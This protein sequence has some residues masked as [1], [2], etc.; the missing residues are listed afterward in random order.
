MSTI[1]NEIINA[2]EGKWP[3]FIFKNEE[4]EPVNF[5]YNQNNIFYINGE[6]DTIFNEKLRYM[7]INPYTLECTF[8]TFKI[9]DKDISLYLVILNNIAI[10]IST[11]NDP[12]F[13]TFERTSPPIPTTSPPPTPPPTPSPT[14]IPIVDPSYMLGEWI[15]YSL[16]IGQAG[17]VTIT[18]LGDNNFY[19]DGPNIADITF[20]AG[21]DR[22]KYLHIDP[23]TLNVYLPR[24]YN[25]YIG[26]LTVIEIDGRKIG[27]A[28]TPDAGKYSLIRYRN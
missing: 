4:Y 13:I 14:P 18:S 23:Y 12:T 20:N 28:L 8:N 11:R 25:D 27:I 9:N 21:P 1:T 6:K 19:L 26:K 16:G 24:H 5:I 2:I 3:T 22:F 7:S 15:D 10:S 17:P